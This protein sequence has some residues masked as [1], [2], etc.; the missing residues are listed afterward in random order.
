MSNLS[1]VPSEIAMLAAW[2]ESVHNAQ[3]NG[4]SVVKIPSLHRCAYTRATCT[5]K[6][7][8]REQSQD[9]RSTLG[10]RSPEGIRIIRANRKTPRRGHHCAHGSG[11]S[12]PVYHS[13]NGKIN[14]TCRCLTVLPS[15]RRSPETRPKIR[16]QL[17]WFRSM[18]ALG[19]NVEDNFAR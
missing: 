8:L 9:N 16:T 6:C 10:R 1:N 7:G 2:L 17:P 5:P 15:R 14:V 13:H 3:H 19:P 18:T 12:D 11:Q 4:F